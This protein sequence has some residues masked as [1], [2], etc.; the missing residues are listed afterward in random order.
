[1]FSKQGG[2]EGVEGFG[3][4]EGECGDT[5]GAGQVNA[6]IGHRVLLVWKDLRSFAGTVRRRR[7]G[8][9]GGRGADTG[10]PFDRPERGDQRGR[11]RGP[12]ETARRQAV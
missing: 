3:T 6:G 7:G 8:D 2:V 11:R 10:K 4:I 1:M 9:V 5:V 12:A